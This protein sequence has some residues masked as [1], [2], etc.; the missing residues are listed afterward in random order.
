MNWRRT[1]TSPYSGS[2]QQESLPEASSVGMSVLALI[3]RPRRTDEV[4]PVA[5]VTSQI[6]PHAQALPLLLA[7]TGSLHDCVEGQCLDNKEVSPVAFLAQS[8]YWAPFAGATNQASAAGYDPQSLTTMPMDRSM[9][10]QGG[11]YQDQPYT[12]R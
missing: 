4:A 10:Y 11:M 6:N 7:Y 8:R 3:G 1:Y 9:R 12:L 5:L 2:L